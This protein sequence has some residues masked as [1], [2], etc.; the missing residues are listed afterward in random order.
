MTEKSTKLIK[1]RPA[2]RVRIDTSFLL[3]GRQLAMRVASHS[4]EHQAVSVASVSPP[5]AVLSVLRVIRWPLDSRSTLPVS[6]PLSRG[7]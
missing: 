2:Y 4:G 7:V 1:Q 3:Y 5:L 6:A